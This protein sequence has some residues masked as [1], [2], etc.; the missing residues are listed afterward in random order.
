MNLDKKM[1]GSMKE[2]K[3]MCKQNIKRKTKERREDQTKKEK[4]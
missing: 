1:N 4:K 3:E 2:E